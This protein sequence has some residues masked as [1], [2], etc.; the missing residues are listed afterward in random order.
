MWDRPW[1]ESGSSGGNARVGVLVRTNKQIPR[2]IYELKRL[3]IEASEEGGSPL[4]DAPPVAT[5]VSLL[6]L[7]DFPGDSAAAFHV[8]TSPL[9]KAL[10]LGT[11]IGARRAREVSALI[12]TRLMTEGYAGLLRW[13]LVV[14][15]TQMDQ[16][17]FARFNQL[18]DLAP[19][20]DDRAGTRPS[21]FVRLARETRTADPS[22]NSVRVMSIHKSRGLEFDAVVLPDLDRTWSLRSDGFLIDRNDPFGPLTAATRYPT[23]SV[24]SMHP[25]QREQPQAELSRPCRISR[26]D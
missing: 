11:P 1:T 19:T 15:G 8:A 26:R 20:F 23:E 21:E 9:G 14:C 4:M 17:G 10:N 18:I 5:A 25:P 2:L 3:G 22:R 6:Q 16:R 24:R 13:V 7:A 12:R